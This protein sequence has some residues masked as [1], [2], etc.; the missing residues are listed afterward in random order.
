MFYEVLVEDKI[1]LYPYELT[2]KKEEVILNKLR[3]KYEGK[4]DKGL[5]VIIS[6]NEIEHIESDY[7]EIGEPYIKYKTHFK[8]ISFKPEINEIIE[9]RIKSVVNFGVFI[10]VGPIEGLIHISQ[11]G[12]DTFSLDKK[13]NAFVGKN[14]KI[15]YKKGDKVRA[16]IATI[17]LKNNV[18]ESKI[19][20]T[21]RGLILGKI[22][23]KK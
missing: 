2:D 13:S 20:L 8:V 19:S 16:K 3:E 10:D 22:E 18:L 7:I 23:E 15:T 11:L 21:M 4:I 6:I 12:E 1:H 14:T 9:N 5:G 17:S